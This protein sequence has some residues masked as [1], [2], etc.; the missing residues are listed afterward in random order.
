MLKLVTY[1]L[2]KVSRKVGTEKVENTKGLL[3]QYRVLLHCELVNGQDY[4]SPSV[5]VIL[6]SPNTQTLG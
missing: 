3:T 5:L 6:R 2:F 4:Y 1:F